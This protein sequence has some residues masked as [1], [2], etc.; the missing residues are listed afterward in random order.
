LPNPAIAINKN[1]DGLKHAELAAMFGVKP[2]TVR[3]WAQEKNGR[4]TP[5]KV[6]K[7]PV[8]AYAYVPEVRQ[9]YPVVGG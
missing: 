9:W 4:K 5:D 6:R 3:D 1:A 2:S 8:P 7:Q